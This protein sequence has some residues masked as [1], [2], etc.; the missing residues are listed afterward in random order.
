MEKF[1]E[2]E[3]SGKKI[4]SVTPEKILPATPHLRYI[5]KTLALLGTETDE[6]GNETNWKN[7]SEKVPPWASGVELNANIRKVVHEYLLSKLPALKEKIPFMETLPEDKTIE[8]LGDGWFESI[9]EEVEGKR[10]QVLLSVF[11]HMVKKIET[12]IYKQILQKAGPEEME[13]LGLP[14]NLRDLTVDCL[15]ACVKS[16]PLFIRFLA[17][18]QLAPTPPEDAKKTNPIDQNGVPRTFAELF[19]H[20]TQFIEAKLS[21]LSQ[22]DEAWKNEPGADIF[23]EYTNLLGKFYG[24]KDPEKTEA[25]HQAVLEK[26]NDLVGSEF[27]ITIIPPTE[28]YYKPPYLDPEL[29]VVIRTKESKEE[30]ESFRGLQT[31]LAEKL[32]SIG[33]GEF[34]EDMKKRLIR[35]YISIGAYGV[36]TTFV[37]AAQ[38]NPAIALYLDEQIRAYDVNLQKLL[39]LVDGS[40]KAFADTPPEVVEKMSRNDT[41]L[42]ELSHS[43]YWGKRPET[44]RLGAESA[45]TIAE[46]CAESIHRGLAK[47]MIADKTLPYTE[48]QYISESIG[49]A[50]QSMKD[51]NPSD[52][53]F[54]ADAFVLNGLFEKG[55][56]EFKDGKIHITD[57][58]AFFEY[59][60]NNAKEIIALYQDETMTP[61][62]AKK[63]LSEKC[64]TGPKLQEFLDFLK[65]EEKPEE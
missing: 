63:W 26:Y 51:S 48:E 56:A 7:L 19:P 64:V 10:K 11:S 45:V 14:E 42:H 34:K 12:R 23:R 61:I 39:P 47:E 25:L 8:A 59:Y 49:M 2:Q 3:E 37:A 5:E 15:D 57:N 21:T 40:E 20:E 28:G 53:Y 13:N 65:K 36:N 9:G 17:Y 33:A 29:R 6:A 55:I 24:E 62:K 18:S 31:S 52:E 27:P 44:E 58:V 35:N 50:L 30:E 41:M 1:P 46:V 32:D 43:A 22:N 4:H 60:K 16:D 54:K 38:S